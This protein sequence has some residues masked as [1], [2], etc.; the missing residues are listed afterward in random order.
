MGSH[1]EK[2]RWAP[3]KNSRKMNFKKKKI[4]RPAKTWKNA[5]REDKDRLPNV[6][7]EDWNKIVKDKLK[8]KKQAEE[9]YRTP[10]SEEESESGVED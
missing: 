5:V 9:I 2:A 1:T 3:I 6:T 8:L 7:E 10:G 4:G